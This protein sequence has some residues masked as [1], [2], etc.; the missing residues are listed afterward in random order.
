MLNATKFSELVVKLKPTD[1]YYSIN[2]TYSYRLAEYSE[3]RVVIGTEDMIP[4]NAE[5]RLDTEL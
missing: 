5:R 4:I 2:F 1:Q 3:T